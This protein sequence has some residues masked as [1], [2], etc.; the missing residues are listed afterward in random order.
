M[1]KTVKKYKCSE[2][3]SVTKSFHPICP[4]CKGYDTIDSFIDDNS[5]RTSFEQAGLKTAEVIKPTEKTVSINKA[6]RHEIKRI[7]TGIQEF[8]RVLGGGFVEGE[9]ILFAGEP[10]AGKS[11]LSLRIAE[12]MAFNDRRVLYI[13]GEETTDQIGLRGVRMK[14]NDER[15]RLVNEVNLEKVLGHIEEEKPNFIIVDSIQTIVS[16]S[17]EIKGEAGGIAQ[18]KAVAHRLTRLAKKQNI[19]MILISQVIKSGDFAGPEAVKHIVDAA[20]M[21]ESDKDSILKFL[22]PSKNRFGNTTE[23]GVFQHTETGLEEVVDPSGIFLDDENGAVSGASCSFMTEGIRQIPIEIQ[24]LVTPSSLTNPRKQFSGVNH[25]RGQIVCAILDKFNYAKLFEKDVFVS[26]V[27]GVKVNDPQSDLSIAAS[28]LSSNIDK[29]PNEKTLFVGEL[30]LTGQV[31]G[32]FMI[33]NKIK[34]AERLGFSQ[35]VIPKVALKSI[36]YKP[37]KIKIHGISSI[38]ELTKFIK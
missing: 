7:P 6:A 14:V 28:I 26:T 17:S 31:R 10:G 33:D 9:V 23:V 20:F 5:G 21:L 13:S 34:E 18:S 25:Q 16:T 38:S 15:I 24:A 32:S 3:E 22:R 35:I 30:S 19:I 1:A 37:K 11:T 27:N 8:D 12:K 4:T 29:K 36:N 2:C